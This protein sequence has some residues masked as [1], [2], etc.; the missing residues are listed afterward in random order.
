LASANPLVEPL[1]KDV[2]PTFAPPLQIAAMLRY[3]WPALSGE[4][5]AQVNGSYTDSFF[6]NLRNFD[7][8]QYDSYT[9][10]NLRFGYAPEGGN[11]EVAAFVKNV[12]D[13]RYRTVGYN[14]ATLCGCSEDGYGQ[15]RWAGVTF[16]LKLD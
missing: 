5:S 16:K 8:E 9:L 2:E 7:S 13:E 3:A 10:A 15:P 4:L 11:W 1:F 14:L 6:Y 12:T